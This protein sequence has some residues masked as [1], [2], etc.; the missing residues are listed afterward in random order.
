MDNSKDN[1]GSIHSDTSQHHDTGENSEM[2]NN[3][4]QFTK[5]NDSVSK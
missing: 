3:I 2:F 1:S 5:R 4:H